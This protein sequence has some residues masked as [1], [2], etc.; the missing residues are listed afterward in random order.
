MFSK[1]L[2]SD[3]STCFR[4]AVRY[5]ICSFK[6]AIWSF[7]Q[8]HKFEHT[9]SAKLSRESPSIPACPCWWAASS[10]SICCS[11]SSRGAV[12]RGRC[13]PFS[14]VG[15]SSMSSIGA[16]SNLIRLDSNCFCFSKCCFLL[17]AASRS[18]VNFFCCLSKCVTAELS[19][20]QTQALKHCAWKCWKKWLRTS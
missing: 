1:T 20:S 9:L 6:F 10:K 11:P 7:I 4:S 5:P 19:T 12:I 16:R 2:R 13:W 8:K 14:S 3:S 15:A 17:M 18:R